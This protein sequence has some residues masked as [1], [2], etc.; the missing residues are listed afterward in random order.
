PGVVVNNVLV[1]VVESHLES[2]GPLLITHWGMSA[3]AILKL[4]AFGALELAK[5][6]Y[7]FKITINFINT[8][9]EDCLD[10]L[11]ALKQELAKKTVYKSAQFDV[12]KRLWQKLVLVSKMDNETRWADLNKDQ[13]ETLASQLTQAVF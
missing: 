4:S 2:S 10:I 1:N 11:K 6:D 13:L 12:P 3:P 5:R 8:S 9:F 7:K